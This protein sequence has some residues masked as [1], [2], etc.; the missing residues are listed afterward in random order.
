M[1]RSQD[2][3]GLIRGIQLVANASL[4][5]Q[6]A[7]LKH[8]WSHSSV[9]E[10]IEKN[11]EQTAECGKKVASNPGQELQNIGS[12]IKETFER[13]AV[14]AEGIRRYTASGR[15]TYPIGEIEMSQDTKTYSTIKNIKNLDIASITLK[16]LENLLTEHNKMREVSLR[17]DESFKPKA[18]KMKKPKPEPILNVDP[19]VPPVVQAPPPPPR[20]VIDATPDVAKDEKQVESM[21]KFITNYDREPV[22]NTTVASPVP[23]VSQTT[24][25]LFR[26]SRR[27]FTNPKIIS[28]QFSFHSALA[29][30]P[31]SDGMS[32]P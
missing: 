31:A 13:S 3:L 10:V 29:S 9:R 23:E 24:K 15:T 26:C 18:K 16:E 20:P 1:S 25:T 7:Y 21:L 19:V 17:L 6:E 11:I 8:L 30:S 28:S 14:V 2:I 5:T 4:K 32:A 22:N 27:A 12:A